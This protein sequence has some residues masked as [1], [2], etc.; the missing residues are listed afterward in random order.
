ME[1]SFVTAAL[2]RRWWVVAAFAV[3]GLIPLFFAGGSASNTYESVALLEVLPNDDTRVSGT[4]DRYVLSQVEELTSS[5]IAEDVAA[6]LSSADQAG[7]VQRATTIE[8]TPETDIVVVRVRQ[9]DDPE[10]AQLIA[11]TIVAT[12]IDRLEEAENS[13]R[14]ADI[15]AYDAEL[16]ALDLQLDAAND[17]IQTAMQPFILRVGE[18]NFSV[19]PVDI[20]IPSAVSDRTLLTTE[21]QRLAQLKAALEDQESKINTRIVQ[22]ATLPGAPIA[23]GDGLIRIAMFVALS[24][25]GVTVALLWARFSTKVLDEV[26]VEE[27]LDVP[28]S[29]TL[30]RNRQL[31]QDPM[32]A[33]TRLP[34]ELIGAVDHLAVQAEALASINQPLRIAVVGSQRG[35]GTTT[36]ALALAA[37]FAA[38]EYSVVV[39]DADRRDPWVTDVFGADQHGGVPALLG[40]G[41][42]SDRIFTRTSEPDVRVL[43][44][45]AE[46]AALR[47]ESVPSLV[48]AVST[49]ANVVIFDG[50][51][52]M[53]AAATVELCHNV[54]AIVLAVPEREQRT[55][56]LVTVAR[57]IAPVRERLLPVLTHP[58]RAE[59]VRTRPTDSVYDAT[60]WNPGPAGDPGPASSAT[61]G[62]NGSSGNGGRKRP[63]KASRSSD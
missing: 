23:E 42:G 15:A 46:G 26:A 10:R 39:V 32:V 62:T 61:N 13:A 18:P 53:D 37:R 34:Q 2:R 28:V 49:A 36:T 11:Q 33:L 14:A 48:S 8:Q 38:A 55:D 56:V 1:L 50:G 19:P 9:T 63:A 57:Q 22:P 3:L 17:A 27:V 59:A 4:A 40:A 44:L 7:Q 29:T 16:E 47:R 24:L 58:T 52:L 60:S 35:A 51:P 12:Y 43:G 21:I 31:R 20:V 45:G 6:Q 25:L 41:E 54:D 5:S 30:G